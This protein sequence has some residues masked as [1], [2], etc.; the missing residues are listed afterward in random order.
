[1]FGKPDINKPSA[2]QKLDHF[3][4]GISL[5]LHSWPALSLAVAN[6]W[7]SLSEQE[8]ADKRDWLGGVIADLFSERPDTDQEDVEDVLLQVMGDEFEVQVEDG[9]ETE[10]AAQ[11]MRTRVECERGEFGNVR[12]MYRAWEERK[13]RPLSLPNEMQFARNAGQEDE[14][15]EEDESGEDGEEADVNMEDA[16][17]MIPDLVPARKEAK[18]SDPEIDEDGFTK[19]VGKRKGR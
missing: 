17:E 18:R 3:T 6:S 2:A 12:D 16:H 14:N 13:G 8:A 7:G 10:V 9:S 19:V 4:L 15:D 1:M 11:I 5:H